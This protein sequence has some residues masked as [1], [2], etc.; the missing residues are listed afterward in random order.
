[1]KP[2]ALSL[3][4]LLSFAALCNA[5][6]PDRYFEVSK[7]L[8]IF[9]SLFREL[10]L[11]YVDTIDVKALVRTAVDEMLES[12]DPYTSY[13]SEEEIKEFEYI[14]T[15]EYGG[16]GA[17]IGKKGD[18]IAVIE[19]YENMPA[20]K[21]GIQTGD[22]IT[23]IGGTRIAATETTTAVSEMLKGEPGTSVTV[24]VKRA[25]EH[26]EITLEIVRENIQTDA[27]TYYNMYDSIAYIHLSAFTDKAYSELKRA[28]IELK[29]KHNPQGLIIDLRGNAGGIVDEAV[30]I[31]SLFVP[32]GTEIVALRG[33]NSQWDNVYRTL[34]EPMDVHIPIAILVDGMSAS[35]A[36]IL[37]G[38][39][40]DLDRAAIVGSRTFGKG[41][42][43]STRPLEFNSYLKVTT[44][45]YY[46]PSGRCIQEID[47]GHKDGEGHAGKIADSLTREFKTAH[48]RIVRDGGGVAPDIEI[49]EQE[50]LNITYKL[51]TDYLIFDFVTNYIRRHGQTPPPPDEIALSDEEYAGFKNFL[52]TKNFAYTLK[53]SEIL[54][55]L[56]DIIKLEGY[57]DLSAD[58]FAALENKLQPD[59]D[60]DL[61]IFKDDIKKLI[62]IEIA[63]RYYFQKGE[64]REALKY[65]NGLQRAVEVL[66]NKAEYAK[67][68]S[69]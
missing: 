10:D 33:K 6:P 21:N 19:L 51:L 58:E 2:K 57:G 39:L 25:G 64:I 11:F 37:A 23:A 69:P 34:R 68:I 45:K 38:A 65:D 47:Y 46:T 55:A 62:C 67:I 48:G 32:K 41:L 14:T 49:K 1:M 28:F 40:Q 13:I 4:F 7:N 61:E 3:S 16:V 5:T 9:N 29:T 44:A 43:Q 66:K 50:T 53:S 17:I 54:K 20:H 60:K 8:D 42:V 22:V 31:S 18:S 52:Q 59:T 26:K 35:T 12:L 30:S 15:G 56:K 63:K 24:S 36:E 27:V